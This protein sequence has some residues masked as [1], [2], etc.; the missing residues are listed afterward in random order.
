MFTAL[1]TSRRSTRCYI[2][3]SN[4]SRE[5]LIILRNVRGWSQ[6]EVAEKTGIP[7][8]PTNNGPKQ[9]QGKLFRSPLLFL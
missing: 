9:K 5:N 2:K 1:N 7:G 8:R 4:I 3:E 6:E